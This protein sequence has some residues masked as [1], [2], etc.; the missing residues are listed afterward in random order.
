MVPDLLGL[1]GVLRLDL[2]LLA[3]LVVVVVALYAIFDLNRS[4]SV[5]GDSERVDVTRGGD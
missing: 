4:V 2:R 3:F 5:D 1:G